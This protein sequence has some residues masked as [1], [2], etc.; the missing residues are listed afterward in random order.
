[1][2]SCVAREYWVFCVGFGGG[3]RRSP[4]VS[5]FKRSRTKYQKEIV[6]L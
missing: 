1:M 4:A 2:R 6:V 3:R 5:L